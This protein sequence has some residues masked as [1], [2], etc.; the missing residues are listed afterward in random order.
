MSAL[1]RRCNNCFN[2]VDSELKTCPNCGAEIASEGPSEAKKAA[3]FTVVA[4]LAIAVGYFAVRVLLK[5]KGKEAVTPEGQRY[6]QAPQREISEPDGFATLLRVKEV[7]AAPPERIATVLANEL[8]P[9]VKLSEERI[10]GY[11]QWVAVI[12]TPALSNSNTRIEVM[13]YKG[14]VLFIKLRFEDRYPNRAELLTLLGLDPHM[15][16]P[17]MDAMEGPKWVYLDGMDEVRGVYDPQGGPGI[18]EVTVTPNKYLADFF[19]RGG[20][21]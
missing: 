16:K 7:A 13:P 15:A 5:P 4:V 2:D 12:F 14:K 19:A 17:A 21:T 10:G 20:K 9:T 11:D 1:F 8:G 3:L 6:M 18:R